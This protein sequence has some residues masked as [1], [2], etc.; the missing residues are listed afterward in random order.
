MAPL[1]LH[2]GA[3][4]STES[5]IGRGTRMS[6]NA[7]TISTW[8]SLTQLMLQVRMGAKLKSDFEQLRCLGHNKDVCFAY[9]RETEKR[10]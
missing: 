9:L 7:E 2:A 8:V 1:A 3:R 10:R 6:G 5:D 4:D